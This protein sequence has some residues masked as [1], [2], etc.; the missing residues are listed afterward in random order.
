MSKALEPKIR[1][2]FWDSSY[3]QERLSKFCEHLIGINSDLLTISPFESLING[4]QAL[5]QVIF[6]DDLPEEYFDNERN[7]VDEIK[8]IKRWVDENYEDL[9]NRAE[10]QGAPDPE[11]V[12]TKLLSLIE[13]QRRLKKLK[14]LFDPE[15]AF[16]D[17]KSFDKDMHKLYVWLNEL[18]EGQNR[19][20]FWDHIVS[21]NSFKA[22]GISNIVQHLISSL[23]EWYKQNQNKYLI[24]TP[25]L[26]KLEDL[27]FKKELALTALLIGKDNKGIQVPFYLSLWLGNEPA[28]PDSIRPSVIDKDKRFFFGH[29][30]VKNDMKRAIQQGTDMAWKDVHN[31][32]AGDFP[33]LA[34]VRFSFPDELFFNEISGKSI[35]AS[36]YILAYLQLKYSDAHGTIE[37]KII[38]FSKLIAATGGT[39]E[40]PAI[41]GL[42]QKMDAIY[43]N[44]KEKK[45]RYLFV[46]KKNKPEAE[47]GVRKSLRRFYNRAY[48]FDTYTELQR[49][50]D[51][52]YQHYQDEKRFKYQPFQGL[53]SPPPHRL[54]KEKFVG[55]NL[56][57]LQ[58]KVDKGKIVLLYGFPGIGKTETATQY[59][60]EYGVNH[61]FYPDG[62]IWLDG[63]S[64]FEL[65]N[66]LIKSFTQ[67]FPNRNILK[68]QEKIYPI[69]D[70]LEHP[71]LGSDDRKSNTED[72]LNI[73]YD[74]INSLSGLLIVIDNLKLNEEPEESI[75][76]LKKIGRLL[77]QQ[78]PKFPS[79][80]LTSC[81]DLSS[82]AYSGS[83]LLWINNI[84]KI[85]LKKL[86][87]DD[88]STLLSKGL[89]RKDLS[90]KQLKN[91]VE[92]LD[93]HP[94]AIVSFKFYL[95]NRGNNKSFHDL[96]T[97]LDHQ[98]TESYPL[99]KIQKLT[100]EILKSLSEHTLKVAKSLAVL[101]NKN[102]TTP[103][104]AAVA[105]VRSYKL[106]DTADSLID[107]G[108]VQLTN[109]G[110]YQSHSLIHGAVERHFNSCANDSK[111][112]AFRA[113]NFIYEQCP[114]EPESLMFHLS[115]CIKFLGE[116]YS[117]HISDLILLS[118]CYLSCD[119]LS[120]AL[121]LSKKAWELKQR[122]P[123][124]Y[125]IHH[126][127]VVKHHALVYEYLGETDKVQFLLKQV[128]KEDLKF[129]KSIKE[130]PYYTNFNFKI[131]QSY[132]GLNKYREAKPYFEK[133]WEIIKN[134][135]NR[136][137]Y[138]ECQFYLGAIY[139]EIGQYGNAQ[140]L[141]E[142]GL[143]KYEK[144]KKGLYLHFLQTLGYVYQGLKKHDKAWPLLE[145]ALQ[146]YEKKRKIPFCLKEYTKLQIE[147]GCAYAL[148][149]QYEKARP[150]LE[151]AWKIGRNEFGYS[152]SL[153]LL[154][155]CYAKIGQYD[156]AIPPLEEAFKMGEKEA[157]HREVLFTLGQVYLGKGQHDE[158]L[159]FFEKALKLLEPNHPDTKIAQSFIDKCKNKIKIFKVG[160]N[161][162][163]PC[164]SGKK[165][166]KCCLN[167]Q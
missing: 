57:D 159:P 89:R 73:I 116:D 100:G 83:S 11:H 4:D 150:H 105:N 58:D 30:K 143:K 141:L 13:D 108:I 77:P 5:L 109:D 167:K 94:Q 3:G 136:N 111:K 49:E 166:K 10:R 120:E 41:G 137:G 151:C 101:D 123:E 19:L 115:K 22:A 149:E 119:D 39:P 14:A 93:G 62:A 50:L 33:G 61:I 98:G 54:P 72:L 56:K 162:L 65:N 155:I 48:W 60:W 36:A 44:L 70:T 42:S 125:V 164:G 153:S 156:N 31:D 133:A 75:S 144:D 45:I 96:F 76:I 131:G 29:Q 132:F 152:R 16:K 99:L 157:C 79:I 9:K 23:N 74:K 140:P 17:S 112:R 127:E 47:E 145:K 161:E 107:K 87:S 12:L 80:L 69:K 64:S 43:K 146:I 68:K 40:E 154:G 81:S 163:C 95:N 46:P 90:P 113:R 67:S 63:S 71:V 128:L 2:K 34:F 126:L 147:L 84:S 86:E 91:L 124:K 15:K 158:A 134:D 27:F 18:S 25:D 121:D 114:F 38:K 148:M 52:A 103:L 26:N 104:W 160:R 32:E 135:K 97:L 59:F 129:K 6:F 118:Q 78:N 106:Q 1:L 53:F 82:Q 21:S 165:Y 139:C 8:Y 110:V 35:A 92:K 51:D 102:I 28:F 122:N 88:A 55:R 7:L 138:S 130:E 20:R 85:N 142:E 37:T 117:D 24:S 66:S